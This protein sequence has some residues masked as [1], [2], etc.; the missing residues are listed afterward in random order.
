M[1]R[2]GEMTKQKKKERKNEEEKD[3]A[4]DAVRE[5]DNLMKGR[6]KICKA[7]TEYVMLVSTVVLMGVGTVMRRRGEISGCVH[8]RKLTLN[9][10]AN[11]SRE[12]GFFFFAANI[13]LPPVSAAAIILSAPEAQFPRKCCGVCRKTPPRARSSASSARARATTS[14]KPFDLDPFLA[15]VDEVCQCF[16][17]RVA[18]FRRGDFAVV[19]GT[20]FSSSSCRSRKR[21]SE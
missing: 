18:R 9:I 17:P 10:G 3:E 16:R 19:S 15:V 1:K 5:A 11:F 14:P 7:E 21:R 8:R 12:K 6:K 4:G 13:N 2:K 20:V